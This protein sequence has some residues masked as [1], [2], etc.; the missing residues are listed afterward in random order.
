MEYTGNLIFLVKSFW[1]LLAELPFTP[2][3]KYVNI[4]WI[5][6]V[7]ASINLSV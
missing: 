4:P 7:I 5:T 3:K 1:D 2:K 6:T